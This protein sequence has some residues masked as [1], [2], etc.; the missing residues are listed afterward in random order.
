MHPTL[1]LLPGLDGTGI[2]FEP[3]LKELP[4]AIVPQ[5]VPLPKHSSMSYKVLVPAIS[6][7][8]PVDRPYYLLGES[9]SGP[10]SL[11]IAES[12]PKGLRGVILCASFIRNPTYVP[13]VLR[14][15]AGAWMFYLTPQFAQIKSLFGG[16]S[17]AELRALLARAHSEVPA[18]VMARRVR[19]ILALD[20]TKALQECPVPVAYLRGTLDMVV[21]AKNLR[22]IVAARPTVREFAIKAP[23]LVVQTQPRAAADAIMTFVRDTGGGSL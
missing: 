7:C 15:I 14:H 22:Q 13:S 16:Y 9:F 17:T 10:I 3:L 1:I 20:C 11:M 18:S 12:H 21:P 8:L 5:V 23:H 6:A 19:S 2:L 4:A